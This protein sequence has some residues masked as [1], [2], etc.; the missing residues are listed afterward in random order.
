ML[1]VNQ[2]LISQRLSSFWS[3]RFDLFEKVA[4]LRGTFEEQHGR[5]PNCNRRK[6]KRSQL[7]LRSLN[8]FVN[9]SIAQQA[10]YQFSKLLS[11]PQGCMRQ[12][13]VCVF[14]CLLCALYSITMCACC[15]TYGCVR[16]RVE[17]RIFS[18]WL[19]LWHI[20]KAWRDS[21]KCRVCPPFPEY[22]KLGSLKQPRLGCLVLYLRALSLIWDSG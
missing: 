14:V 1:D 12:V 5:H 16:V 3:P 18:V 6:P 21:L 11:I 10:S 7:T 4:D 8:V 13:F 9:G 2:E 19:T 15:W 17:V 22:G 20:F